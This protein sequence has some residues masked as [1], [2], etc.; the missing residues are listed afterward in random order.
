MG[1]ET[2]E[3][4]I[5][6]DLRMNNNKF[7]K[8]TQ[9]F[10]PLSKRHEYIRLEKELEAQK[11]KTPTDQEYTEMQADFVAGLFDSDEV[12]KERILEGLDT[13]DSQ[14]ILNIIRYR[15]L[16]FSEKE[17][18]EL[19]KAMTEEILAGE[20]FTNSNLDSSEM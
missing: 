2:M 4:T 3:R 7:K 14:Q 15:V 18:E 9:D 19:K 12:T 13:A 10:V 5:T 1:D 6:L 17:D 16:G 11:E 20:N 8:F